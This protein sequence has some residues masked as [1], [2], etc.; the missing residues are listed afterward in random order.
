MPC[1]HHSLATISSAHR[2]FGPR[3]GYCRPCSLGVQVPCRLCPNKGGAMKT[4]EDKQWAH[5]SCAM[6]VP[7]SRIGDHDA[8]EPILTGDIPADRY[9]LMCTLCKTKNGACMQCEVGCLPFVFRS[10]HCRAARS[11]RHLILPPVFGAGCV[12]HH[13]L[14]RHVRH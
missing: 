6:W 10:P 3:I 7:E 11:G 12:M 14:P 8:M 2:T 4:T 5:M 1:L 9:N 13:G